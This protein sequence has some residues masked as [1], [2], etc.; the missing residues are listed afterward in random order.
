MELVCISFHIRASCLKRVR[1][2]KKKVER[3]KRWLST[4]PILL[5]SLLIVLT[6][7]I[8]EEDYLWEHTRFKSSDSE[9]HQGSLD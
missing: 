3:M 5:L 2:I 1:E 8:L 6:I 7:C 4:H 9:V